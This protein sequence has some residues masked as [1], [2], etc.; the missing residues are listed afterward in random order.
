[1][2]IWVKAQLEGH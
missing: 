1:M 2:E